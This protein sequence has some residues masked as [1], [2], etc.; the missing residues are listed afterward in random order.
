MQDL[1]S[2]FLKNV[3]G[4]IPP[5]PH[6]GVATPARPHPTPSQAKSWDPNLGPLNFSA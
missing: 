6:I 3:P 1:A 4:V 5:N 2:E